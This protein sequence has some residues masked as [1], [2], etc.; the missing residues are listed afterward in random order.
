VAHAL[1]VGPGVNP[2]GDEAVELLK[3]DWPAGD[4]DA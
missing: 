2:F 3:A 1:A 4:C